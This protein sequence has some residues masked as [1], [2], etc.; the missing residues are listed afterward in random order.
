M[1][2]SF[3]T[4]NQ[5]YNTLKTQIG[6]GGG[7]GG[8]GSNASTIDLTSTN[9][10][11]T[12]YPVLA[13]GSGSTKT[14]S[15][16]DANTVIRIN[17][18]TG[19]MN[20]A[21]ALKTTADAVSLG[22]NAGGSATNS[23][24][25]G[26]DAGR[27][28]QGQQ[29]VAVGSSAGRYNQGL[30]G[31]AI[32]YQAG[33]G[34]PI[35]P[36]EG[37]G[38]GAVAIGILAGQLAQGDNA[39]A[40]GNRAGR[41]NQGA[42]S[43]IINATGVQ[44]NNSSKVDSL[45]IA[46]IGN[47]LAGGEYGLLGWDPLTKEV[48][49]SSGISL[50]NILPG[51]NPRL[52]LS[53]TDP[54]VRCSDGINTNIMDKFGFS[55]VNTNTDA[56]YYLNFVSDSADNINTIR[57]TAGLSCN[58]N[59]NTITA[60][61]FGFAD[62]TKMSTASY[63]TNG[64]VIDALTNTDTNISVAQLLSSSDI[65]IQATGATATYNVLL[66]GNL[67]P[68]LPTGR[69]FNIFNNSRATCVLQSSQ[70]A[71]NTQL[72]IGT[73]GS[74]LN[75]VN[76]LPGAGARLFWNGTNF[77][78]WDKG[79]SNSS[80]FTGT[81][82]DFTSNS[83]IWGNFVR[84]APTGTATITLPDLKNTTIT[85][86]TNALNT[87]TTFKNE[88]ASNVTLSVVNPSGASSIFTG[89][90][91]SQKLSTAGTNNTYIIAP[92]TTVKM[93]ANGVTFN[94]EIVE[95]TPDQNDYII[96]YG[97]S[98][99]LTLTNEQINSVIRLTGTANLT[100]T[101]PTPVT[102]SNQYIRGQY[103]QIYNEGSFTIT[104]S[105]PAGVFGGSYGSDATTIELPDNTW[106]RVGSGGANWLVDD[107]GSNI[108]F[109]RD[110]TANLS[111]V[112]S[113]FIVNATLRLTSNGAYTVTIPAPTQAR[114]H[115]T[116]TRIINDSEYT[117]TL[118][119]SDNILGT[120]GTGA[121]TYPIP[122]FSFV[123]LFSTGVNWLA[124]DRN[125]NTLIKYPPVS[126][127]FSNYQLDCDIYFPQPDDPVSSSAFTALAGTASQ[128]GVVLTVATNTGGSILIGSIITLGVG[129]VKLVIL[130]QQ[131]TSTGGQVGKAG[132]YT[133]DFAQ[134]VATSAF[135]G[136]S[137]TTD[138]PFSGNITVPVNTTNNFSTAS[139]TYDIPGAEGINPGAII[140]PINVSTFIVKPSIIIKRNG[141][142]GG[143]GDYYISGGNPT[144]PGA[145]LYF[146]TPSV[147]IEIPLATIS[148][149][150]RKLKITNGSNVYICI[151]S[152]FTANEFGGRY[153]QQFP[154]T[155]LVTKGTGASE[156]VVRRGATV[157]LM[158]DGT[159]WNAIEGTTI[160]G[161]RRWYAPSYSTTTGDTGTPAGNTGMLCVNQDCIANQSLYGLICTGAGAFF[162][163]TS[164]PMT[165]IISVSCAWNNPVNLATTTSPKRYLVIG[166]ITPNELTTDPSFTNDLTYVFT[167]S[168]TTFTALAVGLGQTVSGQ[169][170]LQP[171]EGFRVYTGK[172]NGTANAETTN[173]AVV[174]IERTA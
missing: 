115:Q 170:T 148:N 80:S 84:L 62:G 40:I 93:F 36:L 106:Y 2:G 24:S 117:I 49:A 10:N 99:A 79:T 171:G 156:F 5:K 77:F 132:N 98:T 112:N 60:S 119:N 123:E 146:G 136:F 167:F 35:D 20:F 142:T 140:C 129:G 81:S 31:V 158:S 48:T 89:F 26:T 151:T 27:D 65:I 108:T 38:A 18:S 37:Q 15:V 144:A 83:S 1:S 139:L 66:P 43:T 169:L 33:I 12:F 113:Y 88:T 54:E 122:P 164:F 9:A 114:S 3:F 165:I 101:L 69:S 141:G 47:E 45:F 116:T 153:G 138:A 149:R 28:T 143:A 168:G 78:Y 68:A 90:F 21:G 124:Q 44:L 103:Y 72:F 96:N 57:K 107:R 75:S 8:G 76:I 155:G 130:S 64:I 166:T 70:P 25:I 34:D 95:R 137:S 13:T 42:R 131:T 23:V 147:K 120:Y 46:P 97:S 53:G 152:A 91:G 56:S 73:S 105:T 67:V 94:Y 159:T 150:G 63:S 174:S 58:P 173:N 157:V 74:G 111:L 4:L 162:N 133:V 71:G 6:N 39:I 55:T 126:T 59:T 32:G 16:D 102:G 128:S 125:G 127:T 118:T 30:N 85:N 51:T 161:T 154:A 82:L 104:L 19:A 134:T 41:A 92:L 29:T 160:S 17:P 11:T 145:T 14:L 135:T 110:L 7:G 22:V 50:E 87:Y 121:V 52:L 172:S 109:Q 61:T 86:S 100:L 163:R